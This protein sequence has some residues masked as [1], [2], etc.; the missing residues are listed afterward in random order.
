[1]VESRRLFL[2]I[3]V[4]QFFRP[5]SCA[6]KNAQTGAILGAAGEIASCRWNPDQAA[7]RLTPSGE[8]RLK[9][10]ERPNLT[11]RPN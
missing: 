10:A 3:P 2:S 11:A 5:V 1:V 9:L 7:I 4:C 6:C 8:H